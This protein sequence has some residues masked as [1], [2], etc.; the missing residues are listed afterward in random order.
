MT[1]CQSANYPR[2][3]HAIGTS[4]SVQIPLLDQTHTMDLDDY[5]FKNLILGLVT[6]IKIELE[7]QEQK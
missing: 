3:S 1:L 2:K 7:T 5:H 4:P 6:S